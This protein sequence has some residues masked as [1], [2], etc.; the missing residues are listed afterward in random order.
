M[1][2]KNLLLVAAGVLLAGSLVGCNSTGGGEGGSDTEISLADATTLVSG[3]D[4]SITGTIKA[5]YSA[6]YTLDVQSENVGA[7]GFARQIIETTTVEADFTS[8]S[9][10]VYVKTTGKNALKEETDSTKE[11][12][13]Y[14]D[15]GNYFYLTSTTGDPV[16]V[17]NEAAALSTISTLLKKNSYREGGYVDATSFIYNGI[18][19]YEFHHFNLDSTNLTSEDSISSQKFYKTKENGLKVHTVLDYVGYA[20]DAGTSDLYGEGNEATTIDVTT[21][22]KGYVL[23]YAETYNGASLDMPIMTPAPHLTITGTRS[24]SAT[25]GEEI[26]KKTTIP[27]EAVYGTLNI[28]NSYDGGDVEVRTCAPNDFAHMTLAKN[29]DQVQVGNWICVKPTP[30]GNNTIK[31]VLVNVTS[32]PIGGQAFNGWYCFEAV[33]GENRVSVNFEGDD[34]NTKAKYTVNTDDGVESIEFVTFIAPN[35]SEIT[36]LDVYEVEATAAT[37]VGVKVVT[38]DGYEVA[39]VTSGEKEGMLIQGYYCFTAY[40]AGNYTINVTTKAAVVPTEGKINLTIATLPSGVSVTK[41][42]TFTMNGNV[43][44]DKVEISLVDGK[45]TFDY[46]ENYYIG[47]VLATESDVKISEV[48]FNG[49]ATALVF[50]PEYCLKQTGAGDINVE[51]IASTSATT[52]EKANVT[53]SNIPETVTLTLKQ[54]TPTAPTNALDLEDGKITNGNFLIIIVSTEESAYTVKVNSENASAIP[55]APANMLMYKTTT[56]FSEYVVTVT[57]D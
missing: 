11:S 37:W 6:N 10:Y 43:P 55:G 23:N 36:K 42:E 16:A 33:E 25:Y 7:K 12:L 54:S 5:T 30:Y 49:T 21:D 24:M 17:S 44:A 18:G 48:K 38:K 50:G 3:F 56:S 9:L 15:G 52:Y 39:S 4:T 51:V 13:L 26:T 14:Q 47:V 35:Y 40:E 34:V 27:H 41:V 8:G 1:K 2:K 19:E 28:K 31:A 46:Q 57:L 29:G 32:T 22:S 20:T 45:Y 53:T